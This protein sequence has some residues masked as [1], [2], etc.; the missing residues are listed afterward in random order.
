MAGAPYA[1]SG[2]RARARARLG[3]A[4]DAFVVARVARCFPDKGVGDVVE[5]AARVLARA[6]AARFLVVGDGDELPRLKARAGELGIAGAVI[7]T[8]FEPNLP[9]ALAA[10][11]VLTLTS[12]TDE[13]SLATLEALAAGKPVVAYENGALVREAVT[14]GVNG[15][16]LP[17]RDVPGLAD[18]LLSLWARP[19]AR[20]AMGHASRRTFE[21]KYGLEAFGRRMGELYAECL[22]A[23]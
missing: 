7:F 4:P 8:G 2:L 6:P 14:P 18:A 17:P 21:A 1:E 10:T 5:A 12:R 20:L 15:L 22:D 9:E 3:I 23:G 13:L 19:E 16:L 11:D